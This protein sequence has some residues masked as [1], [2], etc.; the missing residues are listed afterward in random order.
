[1]RRALARAA[2][3]VDGARRARSDVAIDARAARDDDD[4]ERERARRR[5][6]ARRARA[7]ALATTRERARTTGGGGDEIAIDRSGPATRRSRDGRG[8][9]GAR[10]GRRRRAAGCWDDLERRE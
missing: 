1:M 3:A 7:R 4:D 10:G 5:G 6:R 9:G 2:R 8:A